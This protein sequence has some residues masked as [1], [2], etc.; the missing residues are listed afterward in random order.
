MLSVADRAMEWIS[1]IRQA[2]GSWESAD[3]EEAEWLRT[4]HAPVARPALIVHSRDAKVGFAPPLSV[5]SW[6]DFNWRL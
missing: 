1:L 2:Y 6:I 4:A 5:C 3:G